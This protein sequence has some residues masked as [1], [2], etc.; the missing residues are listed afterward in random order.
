M[1]G[2]PTETD[3]CC[4]YGIFPYIYHKWNIPY[5]D[6]IGLNPGDTHRGTFKIQLVESNEGS[7][8]KGSKG[9]NL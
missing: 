4:V 3:V 8:S 7:A 6:P 5:M 1:A 2:I 9:D